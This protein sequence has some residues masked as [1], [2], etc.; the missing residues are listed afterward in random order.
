MAAKKGPIVA[1]FLMIGYSFVGEWLV[2]EGG[3]GVTLW[4]LGALER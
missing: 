3:Y 4:V 2:G 1:I